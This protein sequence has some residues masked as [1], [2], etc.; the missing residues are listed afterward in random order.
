M[1]SANLNTWQNRVVDYARILSQLT[2]KPVADGMPIRGKGEFKA[3]T[4]YT[5]VPYSNGGWQG[6]MIGFDI[7]LKTFLAA[8]ENPLSVL[9]TID[10]R[11]E[12][13]L[14]AS[15]APYAPVLPHMHCRWPRKLKA[16]GIA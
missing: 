2:W 5:G 13:C 16:A 9:Y 15:M 6:R 7:Y 8:L 4:T 12:R 3:D 10:L 1:N 14:A 11:G